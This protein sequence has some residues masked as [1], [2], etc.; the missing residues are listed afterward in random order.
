MPVVDFIKQGLK[1]DPVKGRKEEKSQQLFFT[2]E[3]LD[4]E[5]VLKVRDGFLPPGR[6][7]AK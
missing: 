3:M 7:G 5:A 1:S 6:R 4:M 2:G